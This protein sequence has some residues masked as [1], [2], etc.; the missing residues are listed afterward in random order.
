[1][2]TNVSVFGEFAKQDKGRPADSGRLWHF[3]SL[4]AHNVWPNVVGF[5]CWP[6][7]YA[8]TQCGSHPDIVKWD[9]SGLHFRRERGFRVDGST[10][11]L[12]HICSGNFKE[13]RVHRFV[14]IDWSWCYCSYGYNSDSLSL[15]LQMQ[16]FRLTTNHHTNK[17]TTGKA[18]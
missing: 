8:R 4:W 18:L 10:Y 13:K 14:C 3:G 2:H 16:F 1:M 17:E 12:A 5:V 9:L 15:Q 11:T 7:N 6:C